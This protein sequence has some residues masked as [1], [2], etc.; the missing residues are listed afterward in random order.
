MFFTGIF[1]SLNCIQIVGAA[2]AP[3]DNAERS[4]LPPLGRQQ[5]SCPDA[6]PVKQPRSSSPRQPR[7]AERSTC[8][9]DVSDTCCATLARGLAAPLGWRRHLR[10]ARPFSEGSGRR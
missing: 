4:V 1:Y 8:Y 2:R 3:E 6:L 10:P 9:C 7:F 5:A